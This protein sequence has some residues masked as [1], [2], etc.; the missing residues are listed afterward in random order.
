[1]FDMGEGCTF[2]SAL[3]LMP[4]P[5]PSDSPSSMKDLVL[6]TYSGWP[7]LLHSIV[8][9]T[10]AAGIIE[11][12][13]C[14]RPP[15]RRWGLGRVTMLGDAAHPVVPALGQ[16][17]N[18]AFEDAYEIAE[19]LSGSP[20]IETALRGYESSRIPRTEAIYARSAMQGHS[21][22]RPDSD[23]TLAEGVARLG[24]DEFQV[25]LYGYRPTPQP[26][27]SSA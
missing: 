6:A 24:E 17:A 7:D 19:F 27:L 15:L 9:A 16:G 26:M 4:E 21:S 5:A 20:D 3:A 11:R 25:W 23:A 14:D 12:P 1:M 18:M 8:K 22:Y 2:W 10:P 13:I